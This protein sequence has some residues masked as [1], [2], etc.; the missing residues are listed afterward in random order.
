MKSFIVFALIV[1]AA[2]AA[3]ANPDGDA[4]I[5]KY[6][7]DNIGLDGYG[8]EVE[9]SNGIK[10]REEGQLQNV[11]SENE[12]LAVR[13]EFSYV[14]NDGQLYSVS[15][16]AGVNGFEASGAHIPKGNE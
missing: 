8:F 16:T 6:E 13:G 11:G 3:P 9:T 1:A 7:S 14:G 10:T 15:Y 2:V 4:Q 12:A 5:I